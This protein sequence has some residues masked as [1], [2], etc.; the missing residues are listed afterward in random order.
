MKHSKIYYKA[1]FDL[2]EITVDKL[3]VYQKRDF[4]LFSLNLTLYIVGESHFLDFKDLDFKQILLSSFSVGDEFLS[5]SIH[6]CSEKIY[7]YTSKEVKIKDS[8]KIIDMNEEFLES[9]TASAD[10][11]Y[12]FETLAITAITFLDKEKKIKTLHSY[13]EYGKILLTETFFD[14]CKSG[15]FK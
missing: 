5:F 11:K 10:M 14:I 2:S 9:F 15:T 13:P 7:N 1:G 3:S 12:E 4:K 8:L 6:D